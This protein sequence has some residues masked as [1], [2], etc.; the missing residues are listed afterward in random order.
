M[1]SCG[2]LQRN[3]NPYIESIMET[4]FFR[5]RKRFSLCGFDWEENIEKGLSQWKKYPRAES[6]ICVVKCM[7][8]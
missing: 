2:A 7:C 4:L 8:V 3:N 6:R 1:L 5:I